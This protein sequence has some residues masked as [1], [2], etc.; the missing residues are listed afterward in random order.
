M[1]PNVNWR[2]DH[3]E[4]L[5]LLGD[6]SCVGDPHWRS[7]PT[8]H[9]WGGDTM[10]AWYEIFEAAIEDGGMSIYIPSEPMDWRGA[11]EYVYRLALPEDEL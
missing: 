10:N 1:L 6:S 5:F 7:E 3:A 9:G 11:I 8:D 2:N 4:L